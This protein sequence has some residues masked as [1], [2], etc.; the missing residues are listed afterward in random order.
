MTVKTDLRSFWK[1]YHSKIF[2][3]GKVTTEKMGII[4]TGV[5]LKVNR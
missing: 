1:N 2:V 3:V 4:F 5:E